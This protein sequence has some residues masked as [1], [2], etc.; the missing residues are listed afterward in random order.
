MAPRLS[1]VPSARVESVLGEQ[2]V[3]VL[4]A[5]MLGALPAVLVPAEPCPRMAEREAW[6]DWQGRQAKAAPPHKREAHQGL[7][8]TP[9]PLGQ[10]EFRARG[11][12]PRREDPRATRLVDRVALR[13]RALAQVAAAA[14]SGATQDNETYGC[15]L[16]LLRWDFGRTGGSAVPAVRRPGKLETKQTEMRSGIDS[17]RHRSL[18]RLDRDGQDS[19][20]ANPDTATTTDANTG[21]ST[22]TSTSTSV[23]A[24]V[25][26]TDAGQEGSEGNPD[27]AANTQ[28]NTIT[29]TSVDASTDRAAAGG[30]RCPGETAQPC[31]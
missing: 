22:A 23:D 13:R 19:S 15:L 6:A 20:G 30:H 14:P 3:V 8:E 29:S 17:P 9:P 26:R 4:A 28:T 1:G 31:D 24:G 27:M 18:S 5:P 11:E 12:A 10:V 21:T 25:D 2:A 7:A 16:L